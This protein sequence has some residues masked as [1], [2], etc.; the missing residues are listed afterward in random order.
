M[1]VS[2][3]TVVDAMEKLAGLHAGYR[4]AHARGTCFDATFTPSGQAAPYTTAAHLSGAPSAAVVRFSH[5]DGDPSTPDGQPDGRPFVRGMSVRFLG[6]DTDLVSINMPVF[7]ASTP[8]KF[9]DLTR[10][11]TDMKPGSQQRADA[12]VEFITANPESV[13]AFQLA[14]ALTVPESYGTTRFW[15]N[16]TFVWVNDTGQRQF[17]RYRWEPVAGV[18]DVPPAQTAG[19]AVDQLTRELG[20]RLEQGPVGF[21]LMVQFAQSGDP[22]DDPTQAWPADRGEIDAGL[23]A[24]TA[25]VADEKYWDDQVFDPSRL[26]PGV[27][28]SD[29]PVLAYRSAAYAESKRRRAQELSEPQ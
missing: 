5:T 25:P 3:E 24:V 27:E 18:R 29:D 17:V 1:T 28:P 19:W 8:A 23:L 12:V 26:T 2:P 14:A 11:L 21:T 4:R 10:A 6:A 15:A 20:A 16:H 22:I 9:L 13:P 7:M